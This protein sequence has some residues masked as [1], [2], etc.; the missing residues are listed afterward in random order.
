MAQSRTEHAE[1][2]LAEL[3]LLLSMF[4][5]QDE[6]EVDQ[7][8]HAE[9]RSYVEGTV[10]CSP[11]TRPEL[12]IKIRTHT[13][14]DVSL[15]CTYPSDYPAVLPEIVVRCG[16]LSRTQHACLVSG[17]RSYLRESCMGE[18]CVLSAVNWLRDQTHVYLE[19]DDN[20]DDDGAKGTV[21]TPRGET[22]TR[23]WIYSH[24][25]Y[26]K[27]KRK[28][29]LEWAKE[30]QLTGFSMPGKPG[31]VCVEGLQAACEEFWARVKV[32]TWKRIMIRHREDVPL[33]LV[34]Q[35]PKSLRRFDGFEEASFDPHGNRGNHMDLGQLFQF[36]SDRGCA[37]IFQL[38]FGVEGR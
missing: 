30:L 11:N 18:V 14:V 6:L 19:Q 8:A 15:S 5:G 38:Y 12:C 34:T 29:I 20:N 9:L 13:G 1:A 16:E 17:L 31:V 27:S 26:N 2:Q 23:L 25:I 21:E 22:F 37:Q 35:N 4:P 32:L 3:E 10:D 33:D 36:L 7:V 28:N 24:H